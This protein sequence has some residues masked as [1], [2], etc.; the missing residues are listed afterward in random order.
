MP[1]VKKAKKKAKKTTGKKGNRALTIIVAE[2]KRIQKASPSKK[3]TSCIKEASKVYR[4][5]HK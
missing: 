4:A 3:W 1:P 2:A 5:K